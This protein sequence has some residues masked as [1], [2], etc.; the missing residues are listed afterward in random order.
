MNGCTAWLSL[1]GLPSAVEESSL[2]GTGRT[3]AGPLS[4]GHGGE[5]L[6]GRLGPEEGAVLW[7]TIPIALGTAGV[8]REGLFP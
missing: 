5:L 3:F 4:R 7:T 6:Q 1:G 8:P 2:A